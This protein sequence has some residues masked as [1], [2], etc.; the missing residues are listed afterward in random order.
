MTP[1]LWQQLKPLYHAALEM[2]KAERASFLAR[3]CRGDH[4][5]LRELSGL[6]RASDEQADTL[7]AP[8]VDLNE[9]LPK[10]R[11][12]LAPGEVILDRFKIVRHVGGGGMGDVYEAID[13]E[14]G[15]IAL[16]AIRSE[17]A[18]DPLVLQQFRKE[19][20]SARKVTGANICRVHELFVAPGDRLRPVTAFLTMEYLEGITLA[21]KM[22]LQGPIPWKEA[23]A[24]ALDI[25]AGLRAIH[26]AG[27]IH[28]DL[29]PRNI[30]LATR[31]GA[32][33][34]VVMDFGLARDFALPTAG[35][36][37]APSG[38]SGI[39]GTLDYMA[40]E[41]FAC[42]ELTPATDIYALGIVLY[43]MV[44]GVHPFAAGSAIEAAV[45]RGKQPPPPC[46]SQCNLPRHLDRVIGQ[47][48]EYEP[49][50]RFPSAAAVAKALNPGMAAALY[51]RKDRPRVFMLGCA[52]VLL[53]LGWA[54]FLGWQTWQYYRP[55]H[56]ALRW[57]D[58]GLNALHE[59]ND[60]KAI[61][62]FDAARAEDPHFVMA[63]ARLA[64]AWENL[65][66]DAYAHREMLQAS[67]GETHLRPLDR[68]YV[69]AIRSTLTRDFEPAISAYQAIVD[70]L[71]PA[72]KSSGYVDLGR[73]YQRAG[74][75]E[76]ALTEYSR[77]SELDKDNPAP[78]LYSGI[79]QARQHHG[80]KAGQAFDRAEYIFT[81]EVNQE[82]LANLD[83]ERGYAA[84]ESGDSAAA[85]RF[86]KKSQDQARQIPS[87]Q[88]EIRDLNQL[89]SV[90]CALGH[91]EE[92]VTLAQQ[93]IHL[94]QDNQIESWAASGYARLAMARVVQG[95]Q[96]YP[97]AEDA[98]KEA[99]LLARQS[100]QARPQALANLVLAILREDEQ[101]IDEAIAPA[102]ASRA[103]Y[104]Q[105]RDFEPA[106]VATL[107]IQ[108]IEARKGDFQS[109]LHA[110]KEYLS[111]AEQSRDQDLVLQGEH[112]V[113]GAYFDAE[114]Y[115]EALPY[116]QKAYAL[117]ADDN[118]KGYEAISYSRALLKLGRIRDA[119]AIL[120]VSAQDESLAGWIG[121]A[122]SESYLVQRKY[123]Q[124]RAE[125][126][127]AIEAHR[128][129]LEDAKQSLEQNLA[130]AEANLGEPG[131]LEQLKANSKGVSKD[132]R[133][134]LSAIALQQAEAEVSHGNAKQALEDALVASRYF[135]TTG[136][137]DS[138]LQASLVAACAAKHL[139]DRP[140]QETFIT[141][142][143]DILSTME[144]NWGSQILGQYL[145]RPDI[146]T[147]VRVLPPGRFS[148]WS[149]V[150]IS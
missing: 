85:E 143:I 50:N 49:Q 63:H 117:A 129:M 116:L 125:A 126:K 56:E 25:C 108:R 147:F 115:T 79:L 135:A 41:Q 47:C 123:A 86:L 142:A 69:D 35:P 32:T 13:L 103:Y 110:A 9:L 58:A 88:L 1:E 33:C 78:Y 3:E 100:Q 20:Q 132:D 134:S 40:P 95:S 97:E 45:S 91:Y 2:P 101:R 119:A 14:L 57:Y 76:Q 90:A 120:P 48:L 118:H 64:E 54:V 4:S 24:I 112:G 42:E 72:D 113:G 59:G 102:E 144:Q 65:D 22:R 122:R 10:I 66:F 87:V 149:K 60:L 8:L 37:T 93:A 137:L 94:A 83:Y 84:N 46:S 39:A 29:K 17:I 55:R 30:M 16:K 111:L 26:E 138:E 121:Y 104:E 68:M 130:V 89:S 124:A 81:S 140:V 51:V 106:A 145:S 44:T 98:V 133:D 105:I 53:A 146:R 99:L 31:N 36:A 23:R 109:T 114:R 38:V 136:A 127:K 73:A 74:K 80:N 62:S 150:P 12:T 107:V 82:G 34:A 11:R 77:A 27:L 96:H 71:P 19:A 21:D 70:H 15:Q 5:M 6:L 75:T 139:G 128:G 52:A 43:E 148:Q 18:D 61:R 67:E 7:D 141:K 131:P 28:R 92:A